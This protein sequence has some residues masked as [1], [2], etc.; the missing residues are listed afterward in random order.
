VDKETRPL[1][2]YITRDG[3]FEYNYM[4]MGV[5]TAT[6][7]FQR[8]HD[9]ILKD[10]AWVTSVAFV[11]NS[12]HKT[13]WDVD[14]HC[15]MLRKV[16]TR[17]SEC[18]MLFKP[19]KCHFGYGT[20]DVLGH[21]I[22]PEG[23]TPVHSKIEA[24]VKATPPKDVHEIRAF[25]GLTGYYKKYV[26]GYSE[27]ARAMVDLIK[28]DAKWDWGPRQRGAFALL[29]DK[30]IRALLL[31]HPEPDKPYILDPDSSEHT[32]GG[33]I[34]QKDAQ[35]NEHPVVYYSRTIRPEELWRGWIERRSATKRVSWCGYWRIM[36]R[37][38]KYGQDR[39][40]LSKR[41]LKRLWT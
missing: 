15:I 13:K 23:R 17:Y 24:I 25:L 2:A 6:Q 28:K 4:P 41:D 21:T 35:G 12:Y 31:K 10:L 11:D 36:P 40:K 39:I 37:W 34:S 26:R 22:T 8:A 5:A 19:S 3:H 7:V 18:N 33:I 29:K 1:L 9:Y 38:T 27:K 32:I 16:L 14:E 20:L 30:L